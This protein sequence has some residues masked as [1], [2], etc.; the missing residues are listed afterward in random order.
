[1]QYILEVEKNNKKVS[2]LKEEISAKKLRF[3]I[4]GFKGEYYFFGLGNCQNKKYYTFNIPDNVTNIYEYLKNNI[5]IIDL[6]PTFIEN[7][8]FDLKC[9]FHSFNDVYKNDSLV[10]AASNED[11]T[12]F[13]L[14]NI[15]NCNLTDIDYRTIINVLRD[16][17]A[18]MWGLDLNAG[19][20]SII[21]MYTT[22][23]KFCKILIEPNMHLE[24]ANNYNVKS[25]TLSL[26]K[27]SD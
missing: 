16:Y 13:Y 23:H 11:E 19:D 15:K 1:M 26:A 7:T 9:K 21:Y 3:N 24:K 20:Y 27:S 5:D 12:V 4:S 2:I 22:D 8:I 6:H 17:Y 10:L 14:Y 25:K 18:D